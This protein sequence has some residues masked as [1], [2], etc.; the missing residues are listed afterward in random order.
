MI[1]DKEG[2]PLNTVEIARRSTRSRRNQEIA[3]LL[4]YFALVAAFYALAMAVGLV[5]QSH[6]DT[7]ELYVSHGWQEEHAARRPGMTY[8]PENIVIEY[9]Q[10]WQAMAESVA[11][12]WSQ[13]IGK[14]IITRPATSEGAWNSGIIT[15]DA[16][17]TQQQ[18]QSMT[19]MASITAAT[20]RWTSMDTGYIVGAI[21]YIP[22]DLSTCV[23]YALLHEAGHAIGITSHDGTHP[24]DVMYSDLPYTCI[25]ALTAQDAAM[26]P[27]T[28]DSCH[29]ELLA[30]GQLFMPVA[31]AQD[32][33][34]YSVLLKPENG[35]LVTVRLREI[36]PENC[37]ATRQQGS[38][39][40]LSDIRSPQGSY[41][42]EIV[43][44]G[45]AWRVAWAES[46]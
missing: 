8:W 43:Q 19:G 4:R 21:V 9:P 31:T 37:V 18:I 26:A 5:G 33:R 41:M 42:G 22:S 44:D 45:E 40:L 13:R 23:E 36:Q 12:K 1:T 46:R 39:V 28:H 24:H 10:G 6:A 3:A 2:K 11:W 17:K 38:S 25:P 7:V 29:A 27:Y 14:T 20:Y 32:G 15:V 34:A 30:N 35:K 16:S